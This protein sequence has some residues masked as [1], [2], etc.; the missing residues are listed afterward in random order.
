M[1]PMVHAQPLA[2]TE[3]RLLFWE[4]ERETGS[5]GARGWPPIAG[6]CGLLPAM[7]GAKATARLLSAIA[8]PTSDGA[9]VLFP[10]AAGT[11]GGLSI[12]PAL[13][14][15]A[16]VSSPSLSEISWRVETFGHRN[17]HDK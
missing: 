3:R 11:K 4:C 5:S 17:T 13:C 7:R 8:T 16:T 1:Q 15:S 14:C 10:R 6:I 12:K 2:L 9:G